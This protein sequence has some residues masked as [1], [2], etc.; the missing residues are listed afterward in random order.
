MTKLFLNAKKR[1][2]LGSNKSTHLRKEGLIPGI[3]FGSH[4]TA[5]PVTLEKMEFEKF[6]AQNRVG[7]KVFVK[8]E[9]KEVMALLKE[10]QKDVFGASV[11]HVDLQALSKMDKVKL[12]V[13][14]NYVGKDKLPNDLIAQEHASELEIETLPEFL[15]DVITVD[16]SEMKFG[17]VLKVSDLPIMKDANIK[18]LSQQ[19]MALFNLVYPAKVQEEVVDE[20]AAAVVVAPAEEVK[21]EK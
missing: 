3:L 11:L 7:S 21:A 14:L 12:H 19:D 1:D 6:I 13:R 2:A 17:D 16:V 5:Q 18:V 20:V 10:V 15:I 9:G 8:I 4:M